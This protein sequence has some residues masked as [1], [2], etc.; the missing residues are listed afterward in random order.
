[1]DGERWFAVAFLAWILIM[2]ALVHYQALS[3]GVRDLGY[4]IR[5]LRRDVGAAQ[6]EI[7]FHREQNDRDADRILSELR[8]IR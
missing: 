8:R 5:D 2:T 7:E 6:R 4:Q 1:M 3:S